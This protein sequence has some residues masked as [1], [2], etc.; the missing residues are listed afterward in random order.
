VFQPPPTTTFNRAFQETFRE[1]RL[2]LGVFFPIEAFAGSTPTMAGQAELARHAEQLGF[3]ALWFRDVPLLDPDSGEVGQVFDPW[4]YLGY[5]AARTKSIHLA[6]GSIILPLRHPLHTAKA[7]ASVNELSG[8]RLMLGVASSERMIEYPA[9]GVNL[10]TPGPRFRQA[11]DD[12]QRALHESFPRMDTP[13]TRLHGAHLGVQADIGEFRAVRTRL[14]V[15]RR[16]QR[17]AGGDAH[18]C[19]FR[20][21]GVRFNRRDAERA[22]EEGISNRETE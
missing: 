12:I 15:L 18:A 9:F 11:L 7:A 5:I 6:T 13:L 10:A 22:E 3:R 20:G 21:L 17:R 2:S 1:G 4:V 14:E 19:L 8:G 16:W